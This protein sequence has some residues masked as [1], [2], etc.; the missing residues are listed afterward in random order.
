MMW[1]LSGRAST[2]SVWLSQASG[3]RCVIVTHYYARLIGCHIEL[4]WRSCVLMPEVSV[5]C[6]DVMRWEV[7]MWCVERWAALVRPNRKTTNYKCQSHLTSCA[8]TWGP[9]PAFLVLGRLGLSSALLYSLAFAFGFC[10]VWR[11]K[12]LELQNVDLMLESSWPFEV[13]FLLWSRLLLRFD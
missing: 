11:N 6:A 9:E 1:G 12:G 8:R 4:L 2:C 5:R 7:Q 13:D 3:C 10:W